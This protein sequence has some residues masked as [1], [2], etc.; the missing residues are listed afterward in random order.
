MS[1]DDQMTDLDKKVLSEIERRRLKPLPA[2]FFLARRSVFWTLAVVALVLG[3]LSVAVTIYAVVDFVATG[4]RG[5]DAMPLDDVFE[6][7]PF[8]WL[9]ALAV[10][11]ASAVSSFRRTRRGYRYP[12]AAVTLVVLVASLAFGSL[13]YVLNVGPGLH[14]FLRA[15]SPTYE[16]LS[17]SADDEWDDPDAGRLAGRV[18]GYDGKGTLTLQ[19]FDDKVWRIAVEGATLSLDEPLGSDEDVAILGERTGPDTFK[20]RAI[21]EW[22]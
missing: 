5:F 22:D 9:A 8:V 20:A 1:E 15:R 19:D 13:L 7:L 12:T 18:I 16:W 3:A 6:H 10:F 4:G 14:E 2:A 17:S 11:V 21:G